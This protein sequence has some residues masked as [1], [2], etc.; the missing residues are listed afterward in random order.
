MRSALKQSTPNK[1]TISTTE[2]SAYNISKLSHERPGCPFGADTDQTTRSGHSSFSN[3]LERMEQS[4]APALLN[5]RWPPITYSHVFIAANTPQIFE[6]KLGDSS[7]DSHYHRCHHVSKADYLCEALAQD[8]K[9]PRVYGVESK[10]VC[11]P[12]HA[13]K[14]R[15]WEIKDQFEDSQ[16]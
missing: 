15:K 12:V 10:C 16:K 1:E 2:G 11:D 8:L 6:Y 4:Q 5:I 7:L 3:I 14:H 9:L 13:W